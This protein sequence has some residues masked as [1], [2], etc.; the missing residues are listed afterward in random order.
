VAMREY[1]RQQQSGGAPLDPYHEDA[2][3]AQVTREIKNN[4]WNEAEQHIVL[5]DGQIHAIEQLKQHYTRM[6]NDP[7]YEEAFDPA[8]FIS[9]PAE[10]EALT[11]F[12]FWGAWVSG[13]KR[14]GQEY[15][16]THNWPY[17]PAAG[18]VASN[19]TLLWSV[20]SIFG[21]FAGILV[22]LYIYGQFKEEGDPFTGNG[23][24]LTTNDLEV[25]RVRATQRATYKF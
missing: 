12:F 10:I 6:F 13:A 25:G 19:D 2:I 23:T 21:L 8:G 16:Y 14:P 24:S 7:E 15:S 11:S 3:A 22:V 18:N 20:I 5:T 17:D 4:T 1:Y 9:D